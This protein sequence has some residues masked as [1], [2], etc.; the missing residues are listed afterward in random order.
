[1]NV[2]RH[3]ADILER[4]FVEPGE[5]F[6]GVPVLQRDDHAAELT[7]GHGGDASNQRRLERFGADRMA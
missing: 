3:Q 6:D 2:A 1:M 4:P 5:I 7:E